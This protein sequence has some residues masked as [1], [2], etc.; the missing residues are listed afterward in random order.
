[1]KK[2]KI[3]H[4]VK[5]V[6]SSFLSFTNTTTGIAYKLPLYRDNDVGINEYWQAHIIES[7]KNI[8]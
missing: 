4:S 8:Y 6:F 5:K 2:K 3:A 7:V 1:M